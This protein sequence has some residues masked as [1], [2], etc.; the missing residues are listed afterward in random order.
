MENLSHKY[1]NCILMHAYNVSVHVQIFP[2]TGNINFAEWKVPKMHLYILAMT[3][4]YFSRVD[5]FV[6]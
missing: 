5:N 4:L 2:N 1:A 6:V 3:N